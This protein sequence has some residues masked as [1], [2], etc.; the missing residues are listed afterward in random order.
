MLMC[1][2]AAE[3]F[4]SRIELLAMLRSAGR[5]G[6]ATYEELVE[7][8]KIISFA[9]ITEADV[10][11]KK[12]TSPARPVEGMPLPMRAPHNGK[13]CLANL[14]SLLI[15]GETLAR[16]HPHSMRSIAA[17][18]I[19]SPRVVLEWGRS[20]TLPSVFRMF[21]FPKAVEFLGFDVLT[22]IESNFL[23]GFANLAA[24]DLSPLAAVH[25]I[26]NF[27][28]NGCTSLQS[29]DLAPLANVT[30]IGSAFLMN[31]PAIQRVDVSPLKKLTKVGD[32]FLANAGGVV[33]RSFVHLSA[34]VKYGTGFLEGSSVTALDTQLILTH[35]SIPSAFLYRCKAMQAINLRPF[36]YVTSIGDDFMAYSGLTSVS[37]EPLINLTSIGHRFMYECGGITTVDL[38]PLSGVQKVGSD[39]MGCCRGLVAV[40]GSRKGMDPMIYPKAPPAAQKAQ[41]HKPNHFVRDSKVD[42]K[43]NKSKYDR[44]DDD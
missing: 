15:K 16:A 24:V 31:C 38:G 18:Q 2:S 11:G 5:T 8:G 27:F 32:R 34:L 25:T 7:T 37:F 1:L 41:R 3:L 36:K 26:G 30:S 20:D 43:K 10:N 13:H 23:E 35:N 28:L 39:F 6:F 9:L 44:Y 21:P 40:K 29:I 17:R 19:R 4:T 42:T 14:G 33:G 22:T 12:C